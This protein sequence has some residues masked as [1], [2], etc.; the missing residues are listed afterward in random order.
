MAAVAA[1]VMAAVAAEVMAVAVML[2]PAVAVTLRLAAV[3][4]MLRPVMLR[5]AAVIRVV[6]LPVTA[7]VLIRAV[8]PG[9]VDMAAVVASAPEA[10]GG[11]ATGDLAGGDLAGGTAATA[12]ST[13]TPPSTGKRAISGPHRSTNPRS[14][15][16][17]SRLPRQHCLPTTCSRWYN[18]I[19]TGTP[20]CSLSRAARSSSVV[21]LTQPQRAPELVRKSPPWSSHLSPRTSR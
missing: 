20:T 15:K 16:T 2:R 12:T 5:P 9:A 8:K 17:Y 7:V 11:A 3:H 13:S 14:L 6:V 4:L 21:A 1:V 18:S 19:R 10:S